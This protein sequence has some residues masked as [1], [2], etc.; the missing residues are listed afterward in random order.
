MGRKLKTTIMDEMARSTRHE[1]R[2]RFTR[3]YTICVW[4]AWRKAR[5]VGSE[6]P[7]FDAIWGT[8]DFSVTIYENYRTKEI[9][10][11]TEAPRDGKWKKLTSTVSN[12]ST[13]LNLNSGVETTGLAVESLFRHELSNRELKTLLALFPPVGKY[14]GSYWPD[15]QG[16][17]ES[18]VND[19][20]ATVV[21]G[22]GRSLRN[23]N[24]VTRSNA[25]DDIVERFMKM[26]GSKTVRHAVK[27]LEEEGAFAPRERAL[28]PDLDLV[29][30]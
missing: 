6:I 26:L 23:L 8:T 13:T 5:K 24:Q 4:A 22:E 19:N 7:T 21:R 17:C 30:N 12:R 15:E 11:A 20:D 3:L 1:W 18:E 10:V 14:Q 29:N 2:H 9:I 25:E 16:E 28:Q 27:I